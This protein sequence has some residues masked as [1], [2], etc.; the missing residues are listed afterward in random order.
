[1]IQPAFRALLIKAI[2]TTVPLDPDLPAALQTAVAV[3]PVAVLA[4]QEQTLTTR[5]KTLPKYHFPV[6]RRHGT[7]RAGLDNGNRFVAP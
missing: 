1:M 3:S 5:A 4:D 7:V 2:R 6:R